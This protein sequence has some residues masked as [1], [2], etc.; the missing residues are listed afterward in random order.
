MSRIESVIE[1]VLEVS[2]F[3][4]TTDRIDGYYNVH[5]SPLIRK[6]DRRRLLCDVNLLETEDRDRCSFP[7]GTHNGSGVSKTC[8]LRAHDRRIHFGDTFS[9]KLH[10]LEHL[11]M[12]REAFKIFTFCFKVQVFRSTEECR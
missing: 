4:F 8:S 1:I 12:L 2:H 11:H 6:K 9:F 5:L 7:A 10:L 3:T